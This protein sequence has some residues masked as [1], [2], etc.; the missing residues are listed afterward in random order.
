[1][2]ERDERVARADADEERVKG[3]RESEG[4]GGIKKE[5]GMGGTLSPIR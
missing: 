2:R 5:A 1:M 4:G 3:R